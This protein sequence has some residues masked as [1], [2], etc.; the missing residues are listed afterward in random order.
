MLAPSGMTTTTDSVTTAAAGAPATGAALVMDTV[1]GD[2]A[3][4]SPPAPR[5]PMATPTTSRITSAM[6]PTARP[7]TK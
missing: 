1:V 7:R 2:S 6:M 5:V 3:C 4:G